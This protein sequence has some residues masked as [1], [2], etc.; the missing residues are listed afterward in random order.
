[1]EGIGYDDIQ[2]AA[3]R[4]DALNA[5]GSVRPAVPSVKR[6]GCLLNIFGLDEQVS[7]GNR[8]IHS[9]C[10]VGPNHGLNPGFVQNALRNP[11]IR[12]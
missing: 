2:R 9:S 7:S 6:F 5:Q 11:G 3:G 1:L 12:R 8:W 10:V 4:G